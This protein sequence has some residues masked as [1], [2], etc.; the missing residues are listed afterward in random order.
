LQERK[1]V[2]VEIIRCDFSTIKLNN[3]SFVIVYLG[4]DGNSIVKKKLLSEC[5]AGT[6][7]VSVG[8]QIVGWSPAATY[9]SACGIS[10]FRY[11]L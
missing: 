2:L 6:T 5:V 1:K 9:T 7:V 11:V 4:R 3:F 8:F 10:A